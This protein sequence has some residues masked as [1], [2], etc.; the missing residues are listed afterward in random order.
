M[1]TSRCAAGSLSRLSV[2]PGHRNPF[3]NRLFGG[4]IVPVGHPLTT[5]AA[6]TLALAMSVVA[7]LLGTA[8]TAVAAAGGT[9]CVPPP[10]AHRGD[11]ARAPENTLPAFRKALALGVRRLELDVRF[12]VEGTPVLLHDPTVDRTTNGSGEVATMSLADL[13]ALDAGR[14][15]S[16]R[17][18]GVKVPTFYEVLELGR[19]RGAYFL[20]ELKTRPTQPQ[21]DAFLNRI[22][23]LGML[24]RVRV[25]SF[26]EQTVLDVRAAQPGLRTA[27]LDNPSYRSPDSVLLYGTTYV[28]HQNSVT[29]ERVAR[30]RAA[31]IEV[32]P[33]TVDRTRAWR[34]MATDKVEATI[35]NRPKRYLSWARSV[36]S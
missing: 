32:R 6:L 34:R 16:E 25:M 24:E 11:S 9:G 29:E 2:V 30:W 22:R 3:A 14:W 21:M 33:W 18:A 27:I 36:C 12:T 26:D 20:V 31:G 28:V 10:I 5:R 13:R 7:S 8:G 19:T 4:H 1:L 17:Y 23:W 35:T 15:F